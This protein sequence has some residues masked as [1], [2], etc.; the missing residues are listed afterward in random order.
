MIACR[1]N[2]IGTSTVGTN[3]QGA[4]CIASEPGPGK[5][6]KG[7]PSDGNRGFRC[8]R[9]CREFHGRAQWAIWASMERLGPK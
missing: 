7:E 5:S 1:I 8:T 4:C 9:F 2:Q 3:D 6:C